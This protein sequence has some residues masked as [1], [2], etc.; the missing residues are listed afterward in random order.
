MNGRARHAVSD[1]VATGGA[2]GADDG[3]EFG[4]AE[5]RKPREFPHDRQ[6]VDGT[7]IVTEGVGQ[8]AAAQPL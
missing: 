6:G 7:C 8:P 2:I 3:V 5:A 1:L 4:S